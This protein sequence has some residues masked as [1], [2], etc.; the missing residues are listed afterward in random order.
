MNSKMS[1]KQKDTVM[2]FTLVFTPI[3]A[4]TMSRY[5]AAF[6][7][8]KWTLS[9]RPIPFAVFLI[10]VIITIYAFWYNVYTNQ[11]FHSNRVRRPLGFLLSVGHGVAPVFAFQ[12]AVFS[13]DLL[14]PKVGAEP[15]AF[16]LA[17]FYF[18]AIIL[19]RPFFSYLNK[20]IGYF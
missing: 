19:I 6:S 12:F 17:I 3:L 14:Y 5:Y 13:N 7:G 9:I 18:L 2:L 4:A 10:M 16:M 11:W 1:D 15:S 8:Y 20:K